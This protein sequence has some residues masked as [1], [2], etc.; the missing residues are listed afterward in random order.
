MNM[1]MIEKYKGMV[2]SDWS[3]CLSPNGPFDPIS[4]VFPE[5]K[6]AL[7]DVFKLYTGNQITLN[8]AATRISVMLPGQITPEQMDDYLEKHFKTYH[9]L[10]DLIDWCMENSVLFMIN[11]TGTQGY[12]QRAIKKGFI[13]P[14]P[15]IGANPL[16]SY[17]D[18]SDNERFQYEVLEIEDKA[19]C[20]AAVVEK[21]GF[22]GSRIILIGDSG[23]DGPHF[24]W[25]SSIG[26]T[27]VGSMT[28]ASL[29][30]YCDSHGIKI[31]KYMGPSYSEG[32]PRDYELE[33][34]ADLKELINFFK[35]IF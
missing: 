8:E 11:S 26:A 32:D 31:S 19:Q 35:S 3:E 22:S 7:E 15:F 34:T 9:G 14:L 24:K 10:N 17:Q 33:N 2:S 13:P 30:R 28:K 29:N 25:G 16:I 27:L 12:F 20:S 5:L 21:M 1:Q 4:H 6:A 23:G 18:D